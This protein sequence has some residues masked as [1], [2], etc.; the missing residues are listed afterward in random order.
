MPVIRTELQIRAQ[1]EVCFDLFRD[2]SLHSQSVK[3]TKERVIDGA[4]GLIGAG[5]FVTFEA[6][7]LGVRQRLTT[8][9]VEFEAPYRFVGEMVRGA[10]KRF[11]HTHEFVPTEEGT[12]LIDTF[13]YTSPLGP[14]GRLADV[15]FLERHMRNFL[16]HRNLYIKQIAEAKDNTTSGT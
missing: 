4:T 5:E 2:M 12:L 3:H 16:E 11:R 10:F 9:I 14:L 15:L 8:R 6:V 1:I 7:H 13:D